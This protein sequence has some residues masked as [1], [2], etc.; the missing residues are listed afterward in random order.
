MSQ[1]LFKLNDN[2]LY[3]E[4][5]DRLTD[6]LKL[7]KDRY[8]KVAT[9]F[10]AAGMVNCRNHVRNIVCDIDSLLVMFGGDLNDNTLSDITIQD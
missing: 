4:D 5:I 7:L 2:W 10:N 1:M 9:D 6:G 3:P 8:S